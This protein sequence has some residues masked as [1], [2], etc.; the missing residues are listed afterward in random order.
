MSATNSVPEIL[1]AKVFTNQHI[2]ENI[3][4]YLSDDFRKNLD[5]RLVNKSINNTFLRQIRRNHQ[6]MKIEYAY[7]VE[8]S[9]ARSKGF[10]YINYR[11]IYTHDVVGYFIFLNTVVGVKVEKI[12]TRRLWL[13]EEVFKRRLHDIIHSKLIETNGTHIQSLINLEEICNG[14]VKCFNIAKKCIEYGPLRFS[15]L[16]T[17]TYSKNYKKLH[18]TDK[19]FEDIAEYCISKSKNKEECFK[20]LDKTILS[21]ISCDKLDIWINES[22]VLPNEGTDPKYDHRHMPREVIDTILRKWNVKSIKLNILHITNEEVCSVEWLRYDYFTRVRLN[23]PYL[24][25]KQ[26][27]LKFNHVEVSLSYS[28]DCVRGLGNLPGE[29]EPPVGYDNFIPNVRR[30][31]PTDQISME[32]T[33]WYFIPKID[34]EKKMSTILK[35]V[36]MEQQHNLSLDIKFFVDSRIVKKFNEGTNREELLGIASGYV[37]QENRLHCF[38]KSSPFNAEHGPEVFLD[39]KWIGRRFQ[40]YKGKNGN[41]RLKIAS[42]TIGFRWIS[43]TRLPDKLVIFMSNFLC[44]LLIFIIFNVPFIF[45]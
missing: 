22:R 11:K 35:V 30:M 12:T 29:T 20:E 45:L 6:K 14:C 31:F 40:K 18:V 41:Q 7:N 21:T 38:K 24:K 36:T 15:T 23:D 42:T 39:N 16:Q 5:V 28:Q 13:L 17:I 8:H 34:I 32:L 19:L 4:S 10:I 3:L 37:L 26:S 44:F 33:H 1:Y 27:D 2:L 9:F 25:T 43:R